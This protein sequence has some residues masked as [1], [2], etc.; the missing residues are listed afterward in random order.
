M[1][2]RCYILENPKQTTNFFYS[3]LPI[4]KDSELE[5]LTKSK[6]IETHLHINGTSETIYNWH[7]FLDNLDQAYLTLKESFKGNDIL[8]KQNGIDNIKDFIDILKKSKYIFEYIFYE[9][10]FNPNDYRE[11][12]KYLSSTI[13]LDKHLEIRI[14]AKKR[15]KKINNKN[16]IY[17][18]VRFY[19]LIFNTIADSDVRKDI[20]S[21][22]LHYYVLAQSLFNKLFVQQLSQYGFSQFQRITDSK[23]RDQYED[24]GFVDRYKQLE[25]VEKTN[26]LKHLEL[27]FAPKN[28]TYK[29]TKLYSKIIDDYEK[30]KKLNNKTEKPLVIP[31]ISVTTHF[32]KHMEQKNPK[33]IYIRD[34]KTKS[35]LNKRVVSI[36]GL[37]S[38]SKPK[39][40]SSNNP[41]FK[42]FDFLKAI[43]AAGNELYSRPEAFAS[44]F[45]YIREEAKKRFNKHINMTF[46]AG[47]DFVHIVSGIRYIYEAVMFLDMNSKDRIGHATALGLNPE[48]WKKKLNNTI[49]MKQGEY[50]DNLFFI[51]EMI[52]GE[53]RYY[54]QVKHL[55][56][57]FKQT[58]EKVYSKKISLKSYK[59][60]FEYK[61]L[62]RKEACK[63][64]TKNQLEI[65][66]KYHSIQNYCGY[67]KLITLNLNDISDDIIIFIQN[68]ILALL[69]EK[70][71]AIECMITSNTRI[72][73]YNKF[74]DHHILH[75][76]QNP[77]A[78]NIILASDDPGIFNNNLYLEYFILY[79]LLEKTNLDRKNIIKNMIKNGEDYYFS[80]N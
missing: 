50:L 72:S 26:L 40:L 66:D 12:E 41:I 52:K 11:W 38:L 5:A 21:K 9:V 19:N 20:Y 62:T 1:L 24:K 47:E 53:Q 61:W 67:N 23:L 28:T 68:K 58:S 10:D 70:N 49:I 71:I 6:M 8:F 63:Q 34:S 76:L 4:P 35:E 57:V 3:S 13:I 15:Q 44:S 73:F 43:D 79:N 65:F 64:L 78:P 7:Y 25:G 33:Y 77:N 27:R 17:R 45:R 54:I 14:N 59:K 55:L 31:N 56:K 75:W 60:F 18:E 48:I 30:Y 51:I 2:F 29:T 74:E 22:L 32:I 69:K 36:M 46:H 16:I 42:K 80:N 39:Y 37:L